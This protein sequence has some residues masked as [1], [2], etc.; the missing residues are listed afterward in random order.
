MKTQLHPATTISP[1]HSP[2]PVAVAQRLAGLFYLSKPRTALIGAVKSALLFV[3]SPSFR[4]KQLYFLAQ[5]KPYVPL[6]LNPCLTER[7]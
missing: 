5:I 1:S 7:I 4:Y 3:T 6:R 2:A